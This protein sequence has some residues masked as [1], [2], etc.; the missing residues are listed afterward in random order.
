MSKRAK[1][2]FYSSLAFTSTTIGLVFLMKDQDKDN[3]RSGLARDSERRSAQRIKNE[4]EQDRHLQ[5]KLQLEKENA[6]RN[7]PR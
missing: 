1:L 2:T 6:E 7:L 4:M 3:R 5:L